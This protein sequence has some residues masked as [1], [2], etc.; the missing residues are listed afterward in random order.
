MQSRKVLRM[1][2][3]LVIWLVIAFAA[4]YL[5]TQ[6]ESAA[7]LVGGAFAAVGDAFT[8]VIRFFKR[9][10]NHKHKSPFHA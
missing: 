3:K 4:F 2:K 1:P 10:F 5:F 9:L 7:D 6:P 8:K